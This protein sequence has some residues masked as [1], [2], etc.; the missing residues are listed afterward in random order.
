MT[1]K[2]RIL[3]EARTLFAEKGFSGTS[4]RMIADNAGVTKSLI[5]HHFGSKRTL[6]REV[7]QDLLL[8]ANLPEK[9]KKMVHTFDFG[10]GRDCSKVGEKQIPPYFEFLRDNT[11]FARML[12]WMDA[13][14][15]SSLVSENPFLEVA[16]ERLKEYQ[17]KEYIRDDIDPRIL[18][19]SMMAVCEIWFTAQE[20]LGML[21]GKDITGDD[22]NSEYI[23]TVMKLLFEGVKRS[24]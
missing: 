23:E 24:K 16:V 17:L 19:I 14:K 9:I 12:A 1:G 6:W 10:K 5:Y 18:I 8:S 21:F 22:M 11:E 4:I 15:D 13:E 7:S 3:K 2:E 20:R